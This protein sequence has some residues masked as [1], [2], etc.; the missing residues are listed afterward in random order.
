M[1]VIHNAA[2]NPTEE[3]NGIFLIKVGYTTNSLH[4]EFFR[5]LVLLLHSSHLALYAYLVFKC[6]IS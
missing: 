3:N 5:T 2:L 1:D 4:R 6:D